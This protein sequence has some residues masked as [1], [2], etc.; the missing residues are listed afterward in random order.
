MSCGEQLLGICFVR[1]HF[2]VVAFSLPMSR[3]LWMLMEI[4]L[5]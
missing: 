4:W 3:Q 2:Y 5:W 1:K